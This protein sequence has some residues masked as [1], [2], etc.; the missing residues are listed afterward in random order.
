VTVPDGWSELKTGDIILR[1][2]CGQHNVDL[3]YESSEVPEFHSLTTYN[4]EGYLHGPWTS[5]FFHPA[6]CPGLQAEQDKLFDEEH[7]K[8]GEDWR[9]VNECTNRWRILQAQ[10]PQAVRKEHTKW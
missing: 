5:D 4:G 2:W 9:E 3:E 7:F 10:D 8:E 6:N 1:F